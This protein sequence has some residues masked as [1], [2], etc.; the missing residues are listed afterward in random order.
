MDP[1]QTL[2]HYRELYWNP[3]DYCALTDDYGGRLVG[4]EQS[5]A[6]AVRPAGPHGRERAETRGLHERGVNN[7]K[8]TE[9]TP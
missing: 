9:P 5:V 7:G 4:F 1:R 3:F 8:H 6:V 2:S